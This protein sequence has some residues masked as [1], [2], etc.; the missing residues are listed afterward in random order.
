M[1]RADVYMANLSPRSGAEQRGHR[2]VVIVSHDG[3]NKA[4]RW[5]SIIVVPVSTSTKQAKRTPT[6]VSL[7][8]GSGGLSRD[9]VAICHQITTIDRSK[10]EREVGTLSKDHMLEIEEGIKAALS[11]D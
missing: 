3:F 11:M 5:R 7:P 9:S 1:K 4:P 8:A 2:P 10:L 6:T